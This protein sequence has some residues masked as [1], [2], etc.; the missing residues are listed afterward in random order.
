MRAAHPDALVGE[1]CIGNV[2]KVDFPAVGW[3]TKRLGHT[4]VGTDG[5]R[6]RGGNMRPVLVARAEIEAAGVAIPDEGP[7]D[8]RWWA[9][10]GRRL[11]KPSA[12]SGKPGQ[13][14]R[15]SA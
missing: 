2:Y 9:Q 6:V 15:P 13:T 10:P 8:H 1:V 4:A 11:G 7:I 12:D 5:E 3:A 14:A